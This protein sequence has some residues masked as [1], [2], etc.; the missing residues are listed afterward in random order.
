MIGTHFVKNPS[1]SVWDLIPE[2]GPYHSIDSAI[3]CLLYCQEMRPSRLVRKFVSL[4]RRVANEHI[5]DVDLHRTMYFLKAHNIFLGYDYERRKPKEIMELLRQ[6]IKRYGIRFVVFDN[7]HFLI[8]SIQHVP[9][10]VAL[11]SQQF[12]LLAEETKSCIVLIV[13][14]RK[15]A[16]GKVMEMWDARDSSSIPADCDVMMVLHRKSI[17]DG[18]E[19]KY[20]TRALVRVLKNRWNAEGQVSLEYEGNQARFVEITTNSRGAQSNDRDPLR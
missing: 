1:L 7:L 3:P 2:V 19:F 16:P 5:T 8:R 17:K 4:Y 18:D 10:E 14:P 13:Q 11:Y 9:Q 20:D 12:K 6:T 15:M